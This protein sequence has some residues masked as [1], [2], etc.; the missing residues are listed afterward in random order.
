MFKQ[1]GCRRR[2]K[3]KS[4]CS[5]SNDL[6]EKISRV[7]IRRNMDMSFDNR[8]TLGGFCVDWIL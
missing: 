8:A 7:G 3:D 2:W 1:S 5:T 6:G 4:S